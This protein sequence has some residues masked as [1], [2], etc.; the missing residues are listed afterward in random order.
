MVEE[1]RPY[2]IKY[3][4]E[5]FPDSIIIPEF[6]HVDIMILGPNIPVEIQKTYVDKVYNSPAVAQFGDTSRRQVEQNIDSCKN[7]WLFMDNKFLEYLRYTSNKTISAKL[8]WIYKYYK[9]QKLKIFSI[10]IDGTIKEL[11]NNDVNLFTKFNDISTDK[12]I[13]AYN[14]LKKIGFETEEIVGMYNSFKKSDT[15]DFGQWLLRNEGTD[16]EKL[17]GKIKQSLNNLY[18]IRNVLNC[19]VPKDIKKSQQAVKSIYAIGLFERIGEGYTSDKSVRIRF[20]DK[21]NISQCIGEYKDNKELWDYIRE[22]PVDT[23]TFYAIVR[24][25]YPNFLR[26]RQKQKNIEEAWTK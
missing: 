3:L 16:R 14:I 7:C 11:E 19:S 4:K 10:T 8:D 26:D 6:N 24:G 5:I 2:I 12:Y 13:I 25:E 15:R 1:I 23:R 20:I 18:D 17:Y 22:H 21:Y 9:E